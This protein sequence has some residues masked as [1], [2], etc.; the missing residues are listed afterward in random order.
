M[1]GDNMAYITTTNAEG[2]APGK[3][4]SLYLR[5]VQRLKREDRLE[6]AIASLLDL[7]DAAE[8][9]SLYT[10]Q[11]VPAVYYEELAIVFRKRKEYS[12]EVYILDRYMRQRHIYGDPHHEMLKKRLEKAKKLYCRN[13]SGI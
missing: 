8:E 6:A 13:I 3:Q 11:G 12:K 1:Q 9:D 2:Y 7:V 10:G 5:E 4:Q